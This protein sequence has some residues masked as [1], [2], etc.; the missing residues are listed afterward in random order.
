MY[1]YN[2]INSGSVNKDFYFYENLKAYVDLPTDNYLLLK[3]RGL[4]TGY[5]R[6]C[7][8]TPSNGDYTNPTYDINDRY[9]LFKISMYASP[10]TSGGV[11]LDTES[12]RKLGLIVLSTPEM[13]EVKYY[14]RSDYSLRIHSSIGALTEIPE[15][16]SLFNI[17]REID[18][19]YIQAPVSSYTEYA[20]NDVTSQDI[21]GK[22]LPAEEDNNTIVEYGVQTWTPTY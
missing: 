7:I 17:T 4:S 20:D 13:Y 11:N 15:L 9:T 6:S 3:F 22:G 19:S 1:Q 14:Y 8:A 5:Q 21:T 10:V 12:A 2:W 18:S 16:Q